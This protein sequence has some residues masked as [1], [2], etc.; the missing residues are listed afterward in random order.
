MNISGVSLTA[1][2]PNRENAIKLMEYLVGNT[3]QRMYAE[4]NH[5]YPVNPSVSRS[6]LVRSWGDFKQDTT[7]LAEIAKHRK[8]AIMMVDQIRYDR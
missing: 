6:A 1:A 7:A 3:A 5:E 2:A 8:T 4:E